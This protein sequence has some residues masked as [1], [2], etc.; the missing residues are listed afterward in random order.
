MSKTNIANGKKNSVI[1]SLKIFTTGGTID[2]IYFDAKSEFSVGE[3]QVTRI[4]DEGNVSF[5]YDV[6]EL[7]RKD[8]LELTDVD[9][10]EIYTCINASNAHH[11]MITHGTD[12]MVD[13][14]RRLSDIK[15]KTIVLVGSMQPARLA[16]N[17][18]VFNIGFAAAT[19]LNHPHGVYIVMNGKVFDPLKTVKNVAQHRFENEP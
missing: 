9:R 14:A 1:D 18:A 17:D 3:P 10:D 5:N 12:T 15:N 19:A 16:L 7:M 6:E 13:T 8:S 11:I 2:K 4:L